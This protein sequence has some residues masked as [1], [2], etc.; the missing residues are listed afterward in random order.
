MSIVFAI[1]E[2]MVAKFYLPLNNVLDSLFSDGLE[3][4]VCGLLVSVRG[5]Y[6][7]QLVR[8]EEGT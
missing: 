7:L 5:T 6:F 4:C 1:S 2:R 3:L 8:P